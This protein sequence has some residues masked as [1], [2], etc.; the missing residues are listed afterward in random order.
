MRKA[1][2]FQERD[3]M[4]EQIAQS[5]AIGFASHFIG[6]KNL[7]QCIGN[8]LSV[9]AGEVT[10]NVKVMVR[11]LQRIPQH[12]IQVV[13]LGCIGDFD[14]ERR[15]VLNIPEPVVNILVGFVDDVFI[16]T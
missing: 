6:N 14:L 3:F 5:V 7:F 16:T 9:G 8:N 4:I 2:V 1:V 15:L 10:G 13:S 11:V 12:I